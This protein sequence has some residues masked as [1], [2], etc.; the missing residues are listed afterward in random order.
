MKHDARGKVASA[1]NSILRIDLRTPQK[2]M[3]RSSRLHPI[4]LM[5]AYF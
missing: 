2:R 5:R 4:H 1:R 3:P